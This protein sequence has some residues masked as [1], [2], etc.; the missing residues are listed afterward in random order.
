MTQRVG[1]VEKEDAFDILAL[2][3]ERSIA[4]HEKKDQLLSSDGVKQKDSLSND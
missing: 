4:F 2:L 1:D 3:V